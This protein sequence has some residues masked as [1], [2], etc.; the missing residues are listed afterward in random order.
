M[1]SRLVP[2]VLSAVLFVFSIK[3]EA[4]QAGKIVKIGWLSSGSSSAPASVSQLD[5]FR[6]QLSELGYIEGKSIA[7]EYRFAGD[8][9]ERLP[10]IV[11]ELANLRVDVLV[12]VSTPVALA[13]K[14]AT[15]TIPVIFLG[16]SD[17]VG[18]GLVDSLAR[19]GGNITGFTNIGSVL[20]GK[21][22]ELLR[23]INSKLSQVAV[24]WN[25][26]NPGSTEQ[27]K[28]SQLAAR[29][30]GLQIYSMEVSSPAKYESTF[31][32]AIKAGSAA[33]A[34]TQDPLATS[35]QKQIL[36]LTAKN[37]LPAIYPRTDFV[38][39]GGLMA[40]GANR[41]EAY[42]RAAVLVDK[43]LKGAKPADLPVEQP[44]KFELVINLKAAKQ[45]GLT[46]P[47]S[48]LARADKVIK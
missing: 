16:V 39:Q 37:R 43:I 31:N 44:T 7:I 47:P 14:N 48:V 28:E 42:R 24:L 36:D 46:I 19:P 40:Y 12:T 6:R 17:P 3:A 22:L 5:R 29:E 9:F 25:P 34:V 38:V 33:I 32:A 27:W 1:R 23:E 2:L 13:A 11:D 20:A 15:K 21:R 10:T 4:Q 35:H 30:L 18:A 8:N 26:H 45:I 41:A